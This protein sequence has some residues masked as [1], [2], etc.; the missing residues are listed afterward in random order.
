MDVVEFRAA[1]LNLNCNTFKLE[2]PLYQMRLKLDNFVVRKEVKG[3]SKGK[4]KKQWRPIGVRR[5]GS[6][7][8]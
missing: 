1:I 3:E 7:I 2:R 6:H 8:V 4:P 5:R